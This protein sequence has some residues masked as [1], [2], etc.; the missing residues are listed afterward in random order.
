MSVGRVLIEKNVAVPMRY[1]V[2]T[3]GDLYRPAEGPA[4]PA[5]VSRSPYDKERSLAQPLLPPP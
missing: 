5:L 4:V 1:G 3:Y 2:L